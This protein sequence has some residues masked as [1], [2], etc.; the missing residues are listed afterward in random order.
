MTETMNVE[1][2]LEGSVANGYQAGTPVADPETVEL[3]GSRGAGG[4]CGAGRRNPGGRQS[5]PSFAGK[6][7]LK[8][9]DEDGG[10][11]SRTAT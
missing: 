6:L 10:G 11:Q 7:P 2:R 4:P 1:V 5:G 8:L 3:R 9:L